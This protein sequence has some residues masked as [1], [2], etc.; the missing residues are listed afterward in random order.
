MLV[1]VAARYATCQARGGDA[2]IVIEAVL[3]RHRVDVSE[4]GFRQRDVH[5]HTLAARRHRNKTGENLRKE[6]L[7]YF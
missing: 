6:G 4:I 3:P 7:I 1:L 2:E 5:A